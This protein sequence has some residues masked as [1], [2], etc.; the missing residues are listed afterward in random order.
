[1]LRLPSDHETA[2]LYNPWSGLNHTLETSPH[3]S[4]TN[5]PLEAC[6]EGPSHTEADVRAQHL[7]LWADEMAQGIK[8]PAA[9]PDDLS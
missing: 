5:Q 7:Q 8:L 3:Q 4:F 6:C 1:M 9:K 2:E